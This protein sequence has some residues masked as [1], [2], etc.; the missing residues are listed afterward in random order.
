M[1]HQVE[2]SQIQYTAPVLANPTPIGLFGLA[3]VTLVAA[4]QKLG[5]TDGTALVLPWAM[6]LGA[7]AQ[8]YASILDAK[9]NNTF[10]ATAFGAYAFFWYAVGMTWMIQN[11][12]FGAQMQAATDAH[13]LGMAYVGY[14][15]FTLFMTVAAM[16][17]NKVLFIIFILIDFLFLGLSCSTWGI[18]EHEMH[19]V[20]AYAELAIA[21]MSFYGACANMLNIQ[22]GKT[23]LPL[24]KSF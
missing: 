7:S 22:F 6:F 21:L 9:L 15:A 11:G 14:F 23:I 3:M 24:G 16:K 18:L 8:L 19:M 5:W 12:M 17:T 2:Q 4:S 13:Q 10:G 20:A 1:S